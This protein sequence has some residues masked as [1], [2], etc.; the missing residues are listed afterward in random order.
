MDLKKF[1]LSLENS[2]GKRLD[3]INKE[4]LSYKIELERARN[5]V[6][7]LNK[8]I[9]S[10]NRRTRNSAPVSLRAQDKLSSYISKSD[11]PELIKKRP[12]NRPSPIKKLSENQ[13]TKENPKN[14]KPIVK[15]QRPKVL[16]IPKLSLE[17]INSQIKEMETQYSSETLNLFNE[18][19][20]SLGAKSAFDIIKGMTADKFKLIENPDTKVL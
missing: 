18:F 1:K 20:I 7:D 13:E 17:T 15:V 12:E 16:I 4:F 19:N 2:L 3:K 6:I 9:E 8:Y 14:E 11:K 5:Q 10:K